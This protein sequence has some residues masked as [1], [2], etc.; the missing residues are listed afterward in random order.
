[1]SD[2]VYAGVE[3]AGV[4]AGTAGW[5]WAVG[6]NQ[7]D[8]LG[9][10]RNACLAQGVPIDDTDATVVTGGAGVVLGAGVVKD[11]SGWDRLTDLV[12]RLGIE[13]RVLERV[14]ADRADPYLQG[15]SGQLAW[16]INQAQAMPNLDEFSEG[17]A[18]A[19][20]SRSSTA[21]DMPFNLG[22]TAATTYVLELL[23]DSEG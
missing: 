1:M 6:R 14:L 7:R 9:L 12:H 11:A 21:S 20:A 13:H 3:Y 16:L 18:S 5:M 4:D 8:A 2:L 22:G 23:N 17:V 10:L 19:L 15:F